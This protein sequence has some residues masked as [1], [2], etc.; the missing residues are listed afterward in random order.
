M[1]GRGEVK[2]VRSF[3]KG[4]SVW[5]KN[6]GTGK[7]W[8]PG[9]ILKKLGNVN[10]EVVLEE[11]EDSIMHRHVDQLWERSNWACH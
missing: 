1:E 11:F 4:D 3:E 9:I 6:F 8:L 5:I 10:Y 7:K 2:K